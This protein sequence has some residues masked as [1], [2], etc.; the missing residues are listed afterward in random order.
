MAKTHSTGAPSGIHHHQGYTAPLPDGISVR[1]WVFSDVYTGTADALIAAGFVRAEQLPGAPGVGSTCATYYKGQLI[2]RGYSNKIVR[3]EQY[4]QVRKQGRKFCVEVWVCAAELQRRRQ[5]LEEE[6]AAE[7]AQIE[8][9]QQQEK[10]RADETFR[11]DPANLRWQIKISLRV[12]T[13]LVADHTQGDH[14]QQ[15]ANFLCR[16]APEGISDVMEALSEL[17]EWAESVEITPINRTH[18]RVQAARS[19]PAFQAFLQSQCLGD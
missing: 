19:D 3:D 12:L 17:T 4:M 18:L 11:G 1:R 16:I 10:A 7:R 6:R 5:R 13:R 2:R 14:D 8:R 9:E 15:E